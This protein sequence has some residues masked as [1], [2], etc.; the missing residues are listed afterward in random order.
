MVL[1]KVQ[2]QMLSTD[3]QE[4]L[5]KVPDLSDKIGILEENNTE[6]SVQLA[7]KA[8]YVIAKN[9]TGINGGEKIQKALDSSFPFSFP[10]KV[11][12]VDAIGD[13]ENGQWLIKTPLKIPSNTT[14]MLNGAY[15]KLDAQVNNAIIQNSDFTNG[16]VNVHIEGH[17]AVL[18]CNRANQDL[19]INNYHSLGLH[20]YNVDGFSVKGITIKDTARWAFAPEKC[21]NGTIDDIYFDN[22]GHVNQDGVHIIGPASNITV[23]KIRGV[24]GDDAC[25]VNARQAPI[26]GYG[27][28]GDITGIVFDDVIVSGGTA[29]AGGA[30][31]G[32]LRTSASLTYKI[33]GIT[34][35]N[36][37]G[38]NL[39]QAI[40]R[41]GGNEQTTLENHKNIT[42]N[43]IIGFEGTSGAVSLIEMLRPIKNVQINNAQIYSSPRGIINTSGNA[44]DG[45]QINN[46]FRY[47]KGDTT[48]FAMIA[49]DAANV[50]NVQFSNL[51]FERENKTVFDTHLFSFINSTIENIQCRD[52]IAPNVNEYTHT[53]TSTLKNVRLNNVKIANSLTANWG[54]S[55]SHDILINGISVESGTSNTP[56]KTSYQSG[57]MVRYFNTTTSSNIILIMDNQNVWH[58]LTNAYVKLTVDVGTITANSSKTIDVTVPFVENKYFYTIKPNFQLNTGVLFS[59]AYV[60]TATGKLRVVV[61]NTNPTDVT[62]AGTQ[63]LAMI[64]KGIFV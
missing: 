42:I 2:K 3:V 58:E 19:T 28:G 63:W 56:T 16:N 54:T 22:E 44:I 64:T 31:M 24:F 49:L 4:K 37:I 53:D 36:A 25:V 45:L 40:L 13:D 5:D 11:V 50:K 48:A 51:V 26:Q 60:D 32:I 39:R 30:Y 15:L 9:F 29:E 61:Y 57:D 46:L 41:L 34:L 55:A 12:V 62:P 10:N 47:I 7:Q 33:D 14:L 6:L 23:T 38:Y 35:S 18:D 21:K 8:S 43:N 20:L 52:V 59:P 17:G 27:S 1:D